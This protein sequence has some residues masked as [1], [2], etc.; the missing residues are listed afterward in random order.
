MQ[1]EFWKRT[2]ATRES[3]KIKHVIQ[4]RRADYADDMGE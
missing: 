1:F 4:S 2:D 3:R